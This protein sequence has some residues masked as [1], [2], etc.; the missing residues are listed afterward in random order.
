[1][2]L[3]DDEMVL[4]YRLLGHHTTGFGAADKLFNRIA[5]KIESRFSRAVLDKPLNLGVATN[6]IYAGRTIFNVK[7]D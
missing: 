6:H 5:D 1:M 3:T 4:L 7:D 2:T